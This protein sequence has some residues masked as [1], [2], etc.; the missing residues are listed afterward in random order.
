MPIY[1]NYSAIFRQQKCKN[2]FSQIISKSGRVLTKKPR[3]FCILL[4]FPVHLLLRF[5]SFKNHRHV[6][7]V[8]TLFLWFI[9][10]DATFFLSS[11]LVILRCLRPDKI[12]PA[13]QV[14]TRLYSPFLMFRCVSYLMLFQHRSNFGYIYENV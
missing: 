8:L 10:L 3:D 13:V 9:C 2:R 1:A 7:S 4:D 5:Y 14:F 6:Q 11:R 12:V